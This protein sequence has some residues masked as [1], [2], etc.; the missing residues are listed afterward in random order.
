MFW[1]FVLALILGGV[2]L[3]VS[4]FIFWFFMHAVGSNRAGTSLSAPALQ[5][6]GLDLSH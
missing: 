6:L 5:A 2:F 1:V 4:L 3:F